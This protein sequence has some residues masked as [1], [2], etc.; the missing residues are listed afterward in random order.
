[1][2]FVGECYSWAA[3]FVGSG[4]GAV[5]PE[6]R[7]RVL[8][9][10]ARA[11]ACRVRRSRAR[12]AAQVCEWRRL[13]WWGI[14]R[15]SRKPPRSPT[16]ARQAALRSKAAARFPQE[17]SAWGERG[18]LLWEGTF[19]WRGVASARPL[20]SSLLRSA[21]G[22]RSRLPARRGAKQLSLFRT[23]RRLSPPL[24]KCALHISAAAHCA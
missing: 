11:A 20:R 13:S 2:Y 24:R 15:G 1:M 3:F 14:L 22:G 17:A 4:R 7:N 12:S 23:C 6:R 5:L 21:S 16:R 18:K 10:A 8:G 19:L 9:A